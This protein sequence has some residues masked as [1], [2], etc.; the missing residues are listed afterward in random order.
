[1]VVYSSGFS[2]ASFF[3]RSIGT[4]LSILL[5]TFALAFTACSSPAGGDNTPHTHTWGEWTETKA[6]TWTET[7]EE[8]RICE[9][10]P[11]HIETRT[12]NKGGNVQTTNDWNQAIEIIKNGGNNQDY[13]ITVSGTVPV[14]GST[15]STFGSV[16]KLTVT[17]TGDGTLTLSSTGNMFYILGTSLTQTLVIDGPALQGRSVND[18]SLVKVSDSGAALELKSGTISGNMGGGVDVSW[19]GNFTMSGGTISGNTANNGGGATLGGGVYIN[20]YGNF[21]MSGGTISDNTADHGGGVTLNN[22]AIL[23][24]NGGTISG[25]TANDGGGGV[26]MTN[27]ATLTMNGGTISGNTANSSNGGGV[28]MSNSAVFT[29]SGGTISN[30]T[31]GMNGGGVSMAIISTFTMNGGTISGNTAN[32]SNGGGVFV[33]FQDEFNGTAATGSYPNSWIKNNFAPAGT[34][35]QVVVQ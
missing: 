21:T 18:S 24:M 32:S 1:M 16:D 26:S 2:I 13:T 7:G 30:N 25:N 8:T 17:L 28:S 9:I 5:V 34:P 27:A 35:N 11:S 14:P 19:N 31:A 22:A 4:A 20:T 15:G 29:M 12:I 10:D 6:S 3:H 23:T 33:S